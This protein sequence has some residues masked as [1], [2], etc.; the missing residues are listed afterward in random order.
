MKKKLQIT[1]L[2][3]VRKVD[4]LLYIQFMLSLAQRFELDQ[5]CGVVDSGQVTGLSTFQC[6]SRWPNELCRLHSFVR[7]FRIF[8]ALDGEGEGVEG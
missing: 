5:F 1:P 3:T 2:S 7:Y 6:P 4:V 8:G